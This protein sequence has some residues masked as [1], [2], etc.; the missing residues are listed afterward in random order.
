M[1]RQGPNRG[2]PIRVCRPGARRAVRWDAVE[3]AAA[4]TPLDP[5]KNAGDM[6]LVAA[7]WFLPKQACGTLSEMGMK[8]LSWTSPSDVRMGI[9]MQ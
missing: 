8:V 2:V 4:L 5:G 9:Y 3:L 1:I 7:A 6:I